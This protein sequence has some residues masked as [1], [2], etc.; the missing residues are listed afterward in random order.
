MRKS[1]IYKIYTNSE[2]IGVSTEGLWDKIKNM[3]DS[4][5]NKLK[6]QKITKSQDLSGVSTSNEDLFL[7]SIFTPGILG[8]LFFTIT[9]TYVYIKTNIFDIHNDNDENDD[10]IKDRINDKTL[11]NILIKYN[12]YYSLKDVFADDGSSWGW[13]EM[14]PF[15][16]PA[17]AL[18]FDLCDLIDSIKNNDNDLNHLV[19]VLSANDGLNLNDKEDIKMA[20]YYAIHFISPCI[21]NCINYSHGFN[22]DNDSV[23][24]D[25]LLGNISKPLI[26]ADLYFPINLYKEFTYYWVKINRTKFTYGIETVPYKYNTYDHKWMVESVGNYTVKEFNNFVIKENNKVLQTIDQHVSKLINQHKIDFNKPNT[27]IDFTNK[28]VNSLVQKYNCNDQ[29]KLNQLKSI[30]T[31]MLD[32]WVDLMKMQYAAI[33]SSQA[34][35][36]YI[37]KLLNKK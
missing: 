25:R 24:Y 30:I 28:Y 23:V 31:F 21:G 22:V 1:S 36:D 27:M 18:Q 14:Y 26:K 34:D 12:G 4:V 13:E 11:S 37:T 2:H 33:K 9:W 6:K 5:L 7:I 15:V 10:T 19:K 16:V 32:Y 35:I 29:N 17:E 20:L 3:F 8:L